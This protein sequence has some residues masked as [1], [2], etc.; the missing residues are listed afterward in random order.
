M[1]HSLS[2]GFIIFRQHSLSHYP[3]PPAAMSLSLQHCFS[4]FL[5]SREHVTTGETADRVLQNPLS[6]LLDCCWEVQKESQGCEGWATAGNIPAAM[7]AQGQ[8]I[9]SLLC[10]LDP[11]YRMDAETAS[12]SIV[13]LQLQQAQGLI[14]DRKTHTRNWPATRGLPPLPRLF[15]FQQIQGGHAQEAEEKGGYRHTLT[16]TPIQCPPPPCIPRVGICCCFLCTSCG[17]FM[18]LS[19]KGVFATCSHVC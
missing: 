17:P 4:L 14:R 6:C 8:H 15:M 18:P 10:S 11:S 19:I 3:C 13:W 9:C 1:Q 16:H 5:F 2:Q 12:Q 7:I